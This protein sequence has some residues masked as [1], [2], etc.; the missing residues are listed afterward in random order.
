MEACS[1]G[2]QSALGLV[3]AVHAQVRNFPNLST[4]SEAIPSQLAV[5]G[6]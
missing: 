1:K 6:L 3:L 4:Q 2:A 5:V